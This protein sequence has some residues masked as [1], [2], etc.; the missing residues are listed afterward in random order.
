MK[1]ATFHSPRVRDGAAAATQFI[2]LAL[3]TRSHVPTDCTAWHLNR[4]LRISA[5][6][7][8][9]ISLIVDAVSA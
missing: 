7:D 5:I 2:P 9:Q 4:Q 3:E 6:V 8:A 1:S